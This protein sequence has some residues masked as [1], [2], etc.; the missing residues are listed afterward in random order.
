[1]F[2][3]V[4]FLGIADFLEKPILISLIAFL[5]T[6]RPIMLDWGIHALSAATHF[7][8]VRREDTAVIEKTLDITHKDG[9][10]ETFICHLER[11]G[12]F[13]GVFLLTDAYGVCEELKDMARRLGTVGYYR[14]GSSS[15][16]QETAG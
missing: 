10:M 14:S 15:H 5:V 7:E 4:A 2:V 9:E 13:P 6:T 8:P 12:P 3:D 11:N 1:V 16:Y